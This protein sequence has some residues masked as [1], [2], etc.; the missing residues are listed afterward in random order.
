[1][2]AC[3]RR[4]VGELLLVKREGKVR[5]RPLKQLVRRGCP[6]ISASASTIRNGRKMT[7]SDNF[8][9]ARA[10]YSYRPACCTSAKPS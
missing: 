7:S 6:E 4:V 5:S 8:D 1:M 10:S 2:I 3:R 9:N